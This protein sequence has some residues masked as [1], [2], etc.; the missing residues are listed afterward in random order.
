MEQP[1]HTR[2][3]KKARAPGHVSER[4]SR[5]KHDGKRSSQACGRQAAR[6]KRRARRTRARKGMPHSHKNE[7]SD[8]CVRAGVLA[9]QKFDDVQHEP[10]ERSRFRNRTY[11]RRRNKRMSVLLDEELDKRFADMVSAGRLKHN[12]VSSHAWKSGV[13]TR[14]QASNSSHVRL[15][16]RPR[17]L[18]DSNDSM[19]FSTR[20]HE[21]ASRRDDCGRPRRARAARCSQLGLIGA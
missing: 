11:R 2:V 18:H 19:R 5:E 20:I 12:V 6:A 9:R 21:R 16:P 10:H 7:S 4:R 1:A 13:A 15:D 8:P 14:F 3:K 17:R